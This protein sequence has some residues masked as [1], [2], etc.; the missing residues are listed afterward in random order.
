VL[1]SAANITKIE[2]PAMPMA[3]RFSTIF[4]LLLAAAAFAGSAF[5]QVTSGNAFTIS[6]VDVDATGADA[7]KARDQAVREAK[8]RAVGLL[9]ER[10]V[11]PEDRSKVPPVDDA[12]LEGM[13][14]GVEFAKE[15]PAGNRFTGTLNVV[16]SADQVKSWL[17]G[18]GIAV[19]ETVARAALVVPLWKDKGGVE[20]LDDRNAWR[21]AWSKLDTSASAVP[22]TVVRGDQLD[23]NAM[24]VEEA[25]V[26]DVS[27][28][29]RLNAR[30]HLP[31]IVVAI[32]EGD[33]DAG[34]LSVGGYRY[35]TQTGAHSD[36][37]KVTVAG[38]AQLA[39]AAGKVQAK[40]DG[41]WRGMAV[42]R[43]D[44]QDAME[45]TVPIKA[46]SDWVQVRQRLGAIPAIKNV[47]V[48]TLETDHAELHVDYYG[49]PDQLTQ[50]L[51]QAGLQLSKA[52]DGWQ[53][54]VR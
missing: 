37:A 31:T 5:A 20:P 10:M 14:R 21:D 25:Y 35:D 4:L 19:A 24:S 22:V 42:V 29:T 50:T 7:L 43:R 36:L 52:A 12:R 2:T 3:R 11:A 26:G 1:D 28:L 39:D 45:V 6:G 41:D 54:Q 27:A 38:A 40:L 51:A 8:R 30:Y 18:A 33:K 16:F 9:I 23:Q 53:L 15:H 49:T 13:I 48:R 44:S 46:L 17:S 47:V 32:V 34:T